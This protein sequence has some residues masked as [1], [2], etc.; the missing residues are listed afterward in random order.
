MHLSQTKLIAYGRENDFK[1]PYCQ[2]SDIFYHLKMQALRLFPVSVMMPLL[3]VSWVLFSMLSGAL[4]YQETAHMTVLQTTMFA[5]GA[6]ILLGGVWLLTTSSQ[7]PE[8]TGP[9]AHGD[10]VSC[11]A[12]PFAAK[13]AFKRT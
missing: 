11:I 6:G 1:D 5:T 9:E 10:L 13:M 4:Y 2:S 12:Y 3:Q 8:G 7:K